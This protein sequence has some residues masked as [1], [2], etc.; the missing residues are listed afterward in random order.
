MFWK[1]LNF[2]GEICKLHKLERVKGSLESQPQL[3]IYIII[4]WH[5]KNILAFP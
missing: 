5:T 1:D 2:Q 4:Y 3:P